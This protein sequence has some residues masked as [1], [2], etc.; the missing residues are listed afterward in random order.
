MKGL[1]QQALAEYFFIN[2]CVWQGLQRRK[3]KPNHLKF[4]GTTRYLANFAE[5]PLLNKTFFNFQKAFFNSH[6]DTLT[7]A[8]L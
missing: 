7:S 4:V 3:F 6:N 5:N 8:S 1:Y 2:F